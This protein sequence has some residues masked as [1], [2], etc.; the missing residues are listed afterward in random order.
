MKM[1]PPAQMRDIHLLIFL[2]LGKFVLH[3]LTNDQYGFH[4][5]E[6]ATLADAR[7]L[8]W[9]YVAYPP[10]TPLLAR[11]QL[12]LF[13]TSL[14]GF[15]I[16]SSLAQSIAMVI[17]GLMARE[18]GGSRRAQVLA[19]IAV[20]IAPMSLISGALFQYVS[21]DYL[22]WVLIAYFMIRLLKSEDPRW[23]LAIGAVIG[24]GMMTKY[25]IM[26]LVAGLAGGILL[27]DYR[28]YL[29]SPWLWGGVAIS[30]L[31]F[32]PNLFWQIRY[33]FVSLEFL[34]D[35]HARDVAIGR[36]EGFLP[37]Q[38]IVSANL[39]TIP[40]WMAGLYFYFF[41][42]EGKPYRPLGWMYVIPFVLFLLT[43]GR[44]YYLAPAYPMLIAAGA[45]VWDGRLQ[46][47]SRGKSR[48]VLASTWTGL[49]LGAAMGIALMLPV[50]PVGSGWW[51]VVSDVHDN[52]A[53]QIGWVELT[54]SVAEIYSDL[55]RTEQSR[56]GI[57]TANYG[58]AGAIDLYGPT[59]DL[60][61]AI[62]GVNSYWLRGYGD[63]PPETLIVLGFSGE[64]LNEFFASCELA[65]RVTN[66]YSVEN[67]ETTFHPDIFLCRQPRYPWPDLWE[68]LRSFA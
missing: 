45:V 48:F 17:A 6:L 53:E 63:P 26:Y 28:R 7:S 22:W 55:P 23:W 47:L 15:R 19:A 40:F 51:N 14:V 41:K 11:I 57:L 34:F 13:G 29:R 27:T 62:S 37:E 60:P 10:L 2:A 20:A 67:E 30:L 38:F 39:F 25:T 33:D 32:L 21:F 44:S 68:R 24:I 65:G 36:T 54:E 58:E 64:T 35:I 59:Y 18:L 9:G 31:L 56:T 3:L 43:Q 16:L 1:T 66:R 12:E 46:R 8:A 49:I 5:D 4:R 42:P 50:A 52:F 61:E